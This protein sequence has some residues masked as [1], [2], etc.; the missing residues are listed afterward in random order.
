MER[1]ALTSRPYDRDLSRFDAPPPGR[2]R[3]ASAAAFLSF[4]WPGLG[5]GYA[6]RR[7]AAIGFA[8][9]I[10]LLALGAVVLVVASL[11]L[12]ATLI[13]QTASAFALIAILLLAGVWRVVAMHD[14]MT[15]LLSPDPR[16]RQRS[17]A[18]FTVLVAI[19]VLTHGWLA[20]VTWSFHDAGQQVFVGE[21]PRGTPRPSLAPGASAPA[22]D[23]YDATPFATPA[24]ASSRVNVL[25]I[26]VDSAE[27][28]NTALTDTLMVVSVS[29]ETGSIAMVS[30]PRDIADFPL[31]TGGVFNGKI[32]AL[33]AY[34]RAHPDEFPAGPLGTLAQELGFLLGVPIHY[35]AAIDLDG[36]RQMIDVAGGVTV[37]NPKAINDPTY[38]WPDGRRGFRLSAG[39]HRLDGLTATAYVRTR[40]S[41]GDTDFDRA[42][43]Q[44]QLL[45]ALRTQIVRPENLPR[46]PD[47]TQA[48]ADT[49]RT[50]FPSDRI[51]EFL[52]LARG[53]DGDEAQ[54][55]VLGP[56]YA[57]RAEGTADY[58]LRFDEERL[59]RK[60]IELF[61]DDSRYAT[62]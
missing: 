25:L 41:A 3:S 43:R 44:Q 52:D 55:V 2:G 49:I 34:A 46:I 11:G 22:L 14:A 58:R 19:V 62:E 57:L 53:L 56:P 26:G 24:T 51:G 20:F 42:R 61:G 60:S 28:R 1:L 18:V 32:N 17:M 23:D 47:L 10:V 6:G 59:A 15:G 37:D 21:G 40:K 33:M 7:R 8:L 4:L 31:S 50:N 30:F 54:T 45:L 35:Y 12:L 48:A 16:L 5:Q 29:P 13:I 9:P 27:N 39:E 38:D 36:F